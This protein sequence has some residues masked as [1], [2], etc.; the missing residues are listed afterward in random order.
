MSSIELIITANTEALKQLTAAIETLQL[1][2]EIRAPVIQSPIPDAVIAEA[3]DAEPPPPHSIA[4]EPLT[5]E[6]IR[7][8]LI[9]IAGSQGREAVLALLA[10]FCVLIILIFV[11]VT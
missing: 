6:Q 2:S 10:P 11:V 9:A 4:G 7:D 1:T 8:R 5:R 3:A